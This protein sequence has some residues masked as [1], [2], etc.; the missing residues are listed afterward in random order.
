MQLNG[1]TVL[2]DVRMSAE[3]NTKSER[4]AMLEFVSQMTWSSN[5][6]RP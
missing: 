4:S 2:C 5:R 1:T 3:T 6:Q